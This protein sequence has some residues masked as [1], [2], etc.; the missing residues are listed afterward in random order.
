[1]YSLG[2]IPKSIGVRLIHDL[3]RPAG[4]INVLTTDTSVRY[5]TIEDA[6]NCIVAGSYIG[7]IDLKS[8]Y[9]YVPIHADSYALT[10][11]SWNF[12]SDLQFSYMYDCRLPSL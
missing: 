10:G 6:T 8:A 1:M 11:L 3:S 12:Q 4:G 2:A 5:C 7:K 9:R